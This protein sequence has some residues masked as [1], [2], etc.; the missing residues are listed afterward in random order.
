MGIGPQAITAWAL[1]VLTLQQAQGAKMQ[2]EVQSDLGQVLFSRT[3]GGSALGMRF[4]PG[5]PA[6]HCLA[7]SAPILVG[8]EGWTIT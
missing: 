7:L 4:S 5:A 2:G 6:G 3:D 1:Y 8:G